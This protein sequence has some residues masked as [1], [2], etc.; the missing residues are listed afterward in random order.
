[1]SNKPGDFGEHS[2]ALKAAHNRLFAIWLVEKFG[3]QNLRTNL[4]D[5]AGGNGGLSYELSVR[6]GIRCTLIDP[7]IVG[8]SSVVRKRMQKITESRSSDKSVVRF[9]NPKHA[10]PAEDDGDVLDIVWD[11]IYKETLPFNH[12]QAEFYYNSS[13]EQLKCNE[14]LST[15]LQ[16]AVI[17]VGIH[18]DQATESIVDAA[19]H[20]NKSFAVVPCCVFPNLFP[21]RFISPPPGSDVPGPG[22]FVRTY[23][24]L[25]RYLCLKHESIQVG[26]L[27]FEGR[28]TVLYRIV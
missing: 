3:Q 20:L 24:D 2:K 9:Q 28:N 8:L 10:L 4:V 23:D 15:V 14:V 18:P 5:I 25:I 19:L 22:V 13:N 26:Y 16:E 21:N 17:L 6:Y 11:A 7:R 27:P 12:I 1:M